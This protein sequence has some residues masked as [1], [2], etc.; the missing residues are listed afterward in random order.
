MNTHELAQV[1]WS[2]LTGLVLSTQQPD[3]DTD[4]PPLDRLVDVA[5]DMLL[6]GIRA[7]T[8]KRA[9]EWVTSQGPDVV[10]ERQARWVEDGARTTIEIPIQA[11]ATTCPE[12]YPQ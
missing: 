7:T 9:F 8:N 3:R 4:E 5:I 10:W 2:L 6:D 1:L 12:L 11:N